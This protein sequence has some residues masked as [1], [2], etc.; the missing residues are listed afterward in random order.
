MLAV[1]ERTGVYLGDGGGSMTQSVL[2]RTETKRP[3]TLALPMFDLRFLSPEKY[4]VY[5]YIYVSLSHREQIYEECT[6]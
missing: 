6:C 3:T 4:Q 2:L 1:T 5:I